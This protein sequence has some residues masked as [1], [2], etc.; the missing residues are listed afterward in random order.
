MTRYRIMSHDA[1]KEEMKAV[2][3]GKKKAPADAARPSF[4]S[5]E[6]LMR[7]LTK[8]NRRLL[9]Y[10]RDEKPES[11]AELA[12]LTG[13]AAPNLTRTL[14][15]LEAAGLIKMRTV[16]RRKVPTALVKSL[17]VKIDPYSDTRDVLEMA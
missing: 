17:S 2:A 7:L 10:I 12:E 6:A 1:L 15:K 5:V 14:S 11:I 3:K 16:K 4:D 9:A 13:R 8:E